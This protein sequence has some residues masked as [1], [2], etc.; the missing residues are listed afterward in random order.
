MKLLLLHHLLAL[1]PSNLAKN[2]I[3]FFFASHHFKPTETPVGKRLWTIGIS[4]SV[5]RGC[6]G[7]IAIAQL[8][9][10]IFWVVCSLCINTGRNKK[11]E[12]SLHSKSFPVTLTLPFALLGW[13]PAHAWVFLF[14]KHLLNGNKGRVT[15]KERKWVEVKCRKWEGRLKRRNRREEWKKRV[16]GLSLSGALLLTLTLSVSWLH[17][18]TNYPK[19]QKWT[20]NLEIWHS[21]TFLLVGASSTLFSMSRRQAEMEFQGAKKK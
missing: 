1:E 17:V 3:L 7:L 9:S 15:E 14:I 6:E 8:R 18:F 11:K 16:S 4:G 10:A 5:W 20:Q 19:M 21:F 12:T 2:E 13:Y